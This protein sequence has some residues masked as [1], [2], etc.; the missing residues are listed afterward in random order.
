MAKRSWQTTKEIVYTRAAGCCEYCQTSEIN[1]G[2]A[3]HIEHINPTND[4]ELNNLCLSC[5]NCNLS[6]AAATTAIDPITNEQFPLFNPRQQKW[7]EHFQWVE[8][9]T[10]IQGISP[11]GRA[12]VTRFKM[13]RPRIILAR[14]RWVQAGLHPIN[15]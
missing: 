3:M 15:K 14:Q 5:P 12:T 9:H 8:N 2:Q 11:I 6:K 10:Q 1:I 4:D 13:N 7:T